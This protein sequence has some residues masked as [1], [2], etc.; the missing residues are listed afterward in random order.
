[1]EITLEKIELVKDRTGVSYKEA[2][3]A[4]EAAEG[5]VV[6]A[7]IAIEETV[8]EK[9]SKKVN[10]AANDTVEKIKDMVKKGNISKI[11]IK[12]DDEVLL[13]LPL[14]AGLVGALVAPWGVIAGM[15]AAFGFKCQIEL[16]KEDGTIVDISQRAEDLGKEVKEKSAVVVDDVM[17]KGTEAYNSIKDAAA[18]KIS[19]LKAKKDDLDIEVEVILDDLEEKLEDLAEKAE[20]A[21]EEACETAE[22]I[23]E[24]AAEEIEE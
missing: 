19:E 14:N 20:A 10:V 18:E 22:K 2:K 6:D 12:K 4:L 7:I 11:T 23:C 16:Q 5:S 15:I 21:V 1:M 8:D 24:E 17:A 13:N 3:D 9:P